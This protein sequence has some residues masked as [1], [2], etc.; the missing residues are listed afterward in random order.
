MAKVT[1]TP[2]QVIYSAMK[3]TQL[4]LSL[5]PDGHELPHKCNSLI[6]AYILDICLTYPLSR[7]S[8]NPFDYQCKHQEAT[9]YTYIPDIEQSIDRQH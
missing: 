4:Y 2:K 1:R 8:S 9:F 6:V 5:R 7:Y 3:L